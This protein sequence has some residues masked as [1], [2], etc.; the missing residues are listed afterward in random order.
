VQSEL[1]RL[2]H[3]GAFAWR[4]EVASPKD[5][6]IELHAGQRVGLGGPIPESWRLA[7][8]KIAFLPGRGSRNI[9]AVYE[10]ADG[11]FQSARTRLDEVVWRL[12]VAVVA[13]WVALLRTKPSRRC[14]A[15][16]CLAVISHLVL[17]QRVF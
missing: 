5:P 13:L 1:S 3:L 16:P 17:Q 4:L 6:R 9:M 10:L 12:V 7:G 11:I 8:G 14:V 15:T 2:V